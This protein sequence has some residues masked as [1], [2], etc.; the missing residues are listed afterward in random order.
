MKQKAT[1]LKEEWL[2][3]YINVNGPVNILDAEFVDAYINK[4]NPKHSIQ[5][6]GANGCKELG[7]MLSDLYK[8]NILDRSRISI[9]GLGRG[10]PNWVYVYEMRQ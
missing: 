10:Y 3:D 6:F 5:P 7:K 9:H 4:F 1:V 8:D 2:K